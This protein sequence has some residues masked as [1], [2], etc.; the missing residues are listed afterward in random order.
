M[1]IRMWMLIYDLHQ[2]LI[3]KK[4]ILFVLVEG[5]EAFCEFYVC[6]QKSQI[7]LT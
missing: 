6:V 2:V 4:D 1:R 7:N 5:A 3:K